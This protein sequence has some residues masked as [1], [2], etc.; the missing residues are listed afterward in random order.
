MQKL[1]YAK[2]DLLQLASSMRASHFQP[3]MYEAQIAWRYLYH[4]FPT[5]VVFLASC[6]CTASSC[7]DFLQ[8]HAK[9]V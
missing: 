1:A 7:L 3:S 2:S 8:V 4:W 9:M 5:S 6:I